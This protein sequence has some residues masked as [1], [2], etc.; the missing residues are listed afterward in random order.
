M[1]DH[2]PGVPAQATRIEGAYWLLYGRA[3]TPGEVKLGRDYL[4]SDPA[5]DRETA[6]TQYAHV[7]LISNDFL[8]VD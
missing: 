4:Q 5:R 3:P 8:Y 7:L 1:G 6:W 2:P